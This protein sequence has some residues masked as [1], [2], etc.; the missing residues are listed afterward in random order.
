MMDI[1]KNSI[2]FSEGV[3]IDVFGKGILKGWSNCVWLLV[4][5]LILNLVLLRFCVVLFFLGLEEFCCR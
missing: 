2:I 1:R 5:F 3:G 4:W